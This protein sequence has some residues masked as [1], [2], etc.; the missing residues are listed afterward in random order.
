MSKILI[1]SDTTDIPIT[2]VGQYAGICYNS[3]TTNHLKNYQRGLD[4]LKAGHDR[5][6]E[7][8]QIYFIADGYS[9]K[10]IRELYT[11]IAG[12][13]TRLQASTRYINYNDFNAVEP[14]LI[15]KNM[16]ADKI[17]VDTLDTIK[18][19]II[20]LEKLGIKKEDSSMLLPLGMETKIVMRTNLRHIMDMAK[21]RKCSRAFWEYRQFMRDLEDSLA[22]YSDEWKELI[23]E[24]KILKP[25]CDLLGYC[26]ENKSC[27][28]YKK[29]GA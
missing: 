24:Q 14:P 25:K 8:V 7:M 27:G 15:K 12:S 11:H 1:Q 16:E 5:V 17:Y 9:A 21:V 23:K 22:F 2:M 20:E 10:M 26:N 18:T 29:K 19:A 4:C 13:P 3:D 28:R 6:L